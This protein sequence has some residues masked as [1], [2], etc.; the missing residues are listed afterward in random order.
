[1]RSRSAAVLVFSIFLGCSREAPETSPDAGVATI[2]NPLVALQSHAQITSRLVDAK[3]LRTDL[4]Y[5]VESGPRAALRTTFPLTT[6]DPIKVASLSITALDLARS[7]ATMEGSTLLYRDAAAST[8]VVLAPSPGGFE[9]LRVLHD[10]HA[11]STF[12]WR[13]AGGQLR[14]SAHGIEVLDEKG[15]VIAAAEQPWAIDASGTRRDLRSS[16]EGDVLTASLDVAGLTYP[17]VVDP[18]WS[19]TPNLGTVRYAPVLL[20]LNDGKAVNIPNDTAPYTEIY[21]PGTNTWSSAPDINSVLSN[22]T[23]ANG[24]VLSD[25]NVLVLS[26]NDTSAVR[27]NYP[28]KTW[29]TTIAAQPTKCDKCQLV[30]LSDNRILKAQTGSGSSF[31]SIQIYNPTT[32]TWATKTGSSL[33][34]TDLSSIALLDDGRL[35]VI[36]GTLGQTPY[37]YSVTGDSWATAPSIGKHTNPLLL[38]LSDG[39]VML[40]GTPWGA[41][42]PTPT[43]DIYNPTTNTWSKTYNYV[44]WRMNPGFVLLPNGRAMVIGGKRTV[45]A[46]TEYYDDAEIWDPIYNAWT[47]IDP[48]GMAARELPGV[49]LLSGGSVLVAGG[50]TST[51]PTPT[52]AR[53][54]PI[55]DGASCVAPA[56]AVTCAA[57]FCTDGV[58]CNASSCPGGTCDAPAVAGRAAGMCA[59]NLGSACSA[60]KDCASNFCVDGVCC[61]RACDKQCEACNLPPS[62]GT[63]RPT[64]GIPIAPRAACTGAGVGTVCAPSCDGVDATKCNYAAAGT[65][66]CGANSCSA[67]VETKA[68]TCNGAGVCA[69]TT[70]LCDPYVCSATA[71]LKGCSAE[72]DCLA[73]YYCGSGKCQPK[74]GLGAPCSA[75][76]MCPSGLFC[77]DGVC[78]GVASCGAGSSCSAG[79][80]KGE[81]IKL[82]AASCATNADCASG[83]CADGVCCNRA[84]DG[85]CEACNL[86]TTVGTCS[87]VLGSPVGMRAACSG[88]GA[89]TVCASTCNGVDTTKCN[90][91]TAGTVA[92]GKESCTDGVETKAGTCDG[93]GACATS[94]AKCD[95][96]SC[97]ATACKRSCAVEADCAAGYYCSGD[98]CLPKVGLGSTCTAASMCPSGL[99]CTDGVCCG[100]AS[101]GEGSSCAAGPKKGVCSKIDGTACTADSD[102]ASGHCVDGVCCDRACDGQCEACDVPAT[103]GKCSNVFGSP[104]GKRTACTTSA[105]V[106]KVKTCDGKN[107]TACDGFANGATVQCK[108]A[109][110]DGAKLIPKSTCDGAGTCVTPP[111]A[112]CGKYACDAAAL[113]CR[114]ECKASSDCADGFNCVAGVC[115]EGARC[116]E[117]GKESIAVD[118]SRVSC[119]PYRCGTDGTCPKNCATSFDCVGG[120]ICQLAGATGTCVTPAPDEGSGGCAASPSGVSGGGASLLFL[121]V[122]VALRRRR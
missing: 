31:V 22:W 7:A 111:N 91:A 14:K 19:S 28:A 80:K 97:G 95:A 40:H 3:L 115:S 102:C 33:S 73:G 87:P 107:P 23:G 105:D 43:A 16:V 122:A 82:T 68:G 71:C 120:T 18:T 58:C 65:V 30:R 64:L 51:G 8:D 48:I 1:M 25:G 84:C 78:C 76:A 56:F 79:P 39:R 12:R 60:N 96:Y 88:A 66:S 49:A 32:N 121:A 98:K 94:T 83:F 44:R 17:I 63:C 67:G 27:L 5:R 11:P 59:K 50:T 13:I 108:S 9:E 69:V 75:S 81:C 61:D 113:A 112:L 52:A 46:S 90:Y 34:G 74:V 92:C 109:S 45:S 37:L 36:D 116:S 114:T 26:G 35:M 10:A 117:D 70:A 119:A 4:G 54:T 53:F 100:V 42:S 104:H 62:P 2:R 101:C 47:L 41:G 118:S 24:V 93:T 85:Q 77:T 110:C 20:T 55:A 15:V 89:G 29:S 21:D 99:L 103:K 6:L 72:S 106:C 38:K 57:K 86:P